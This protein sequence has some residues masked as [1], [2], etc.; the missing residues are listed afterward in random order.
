MAKLPNI[1]I[2]SPFIIFHIVVGVMSS[3]GIYPTFLH[4]LLC[5]FPFILNVDFEFY[6]NSHCP[7][8]ISIIFEH[9]LQLH[10]S[11]CYTGHQLYCNV[12]W[13]FL[14]LSGVYIHTKM[15]CEILCYFCLEFACN[16]C[17][18]DNQIDDKKS[19][20]VII[21]TTEM[22]VYL[23]SFF[24]LKLARTTCKHFEVRNNK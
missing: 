22:Q 9:S 1:D 24:Y 20:F 15:L 16:L 7:K 6:Q 21:N 18:V 2:S 23:T 11:S 4:F 13:D 10:S 5:I 14:K 19:N 8:G 12:I 17:S 3:E